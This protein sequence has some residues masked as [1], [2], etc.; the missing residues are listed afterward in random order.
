MGSCHCQA[1]AEQFG[2]AAARRDLKRYRRRGP[3]N[4]T[5]LILAGI[6]A[7]PGRFERL[8]DIGAG[9]GVLHHELLGETLRRATHV[10]ASPSYL[11]AAREEDARRGREGIVDY[12]IGDAA[13]VVESL[14]PA[15]V[16]TLDRVICCYPDW[17]A[18]VDRTAAKATTLY[19]FSM[20]HDRWYVRAAVWLIN[21]GRRLSRSAFRA[22]VHPV[23]GVERRLE[24]Q[25]F[26]PI[27][28][29]RTLVWHVALYRRGVSA[30]TSPNVMTSP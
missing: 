26:Q 25:G 28:L 3:D 24:A 7:E 19:A 16:V 30:E 2:P 21:V 11:A 29:R 23:A 17:E 13:D 6:R 27:R 12:V 5:K 18:L 20:P 8:L 9:I 10:D 22:F 15:D 1:T 4:T 14:E